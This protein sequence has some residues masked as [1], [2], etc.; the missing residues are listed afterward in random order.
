ME[1]F[2]PFGPFQ[3]MTFFTYLSTLRLA[4]EL[5]VEAEISHEALPVRELALAH[6]LLP[7]HDDVFGAGLLVLLFGHGWGADAPAAAL[8][9]AIAAWDAAWDR[10][11][12]IRF[13][14]N[15]WRAGRTCMYSGGRERE[16]KCR[17]SESLMMGFATRYLDLGRL[18]TE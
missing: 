18:D 5:L 12:S 16:T 17:L 14:A 7:F 13:E 1:W 3:E 9:V 8:A 10:S 11:R 2:C 15:G 4:G 6:V